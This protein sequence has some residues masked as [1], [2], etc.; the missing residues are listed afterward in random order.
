MDDFVLG[1]TK[2]YRTTYSWDA[3]GNLLTESSFNHGQSTG[4]NNTNIVN[5]DECLETNTNAG[6]GEN[7]FT[8]DRLYRMISSRD[9]NNGLTTYVYDTLGNLL[10]E[11]GHN[12]QVISYRYNIM[13]QL[14]WR[15]TNSDTSTFTYDDRGNLTKEQTHNKEFTYVFDATNRMVSGTNDKTTPVTIPIMHYSSE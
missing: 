14:V 1:G 12:N 11:T 5:P 6:K 15:Q 7:I 4:G 3:V 9:G 2:H 13:N 8:Y 10:R